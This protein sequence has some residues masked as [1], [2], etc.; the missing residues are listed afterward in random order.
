M[1][2][3]DGGNNETFVLVEIDI[4]GKIHKVYEL[5]HPYL[6]NYINLPNGN[7][8][9]TSTNNKIIEFDLKTGKTIKVIDL[10]KIISDVDNDQITKLNLL[11][12][13]GNINSFINYLDYK[14]DEILITLYPYNTI[15]NLKDYKLNWIISEDFSDKFSS[16][17]INGDIDFTKTI[18]K[19]KFNNNNIIILSE[20]VNENQNCSTNYNLISNE[21]TLTNKTL[22]HINNNNFT[23][24]VLGINSE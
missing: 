6:N 2:Y 18:S 3:V 7:I 19:A 14:N 22:E 1:S 11:Y 8:L 4:I 23:S 17:L 16:Y 24:N 12:E 9:Y 5:S 21:Y 15:I 10:N 13:N 20:D